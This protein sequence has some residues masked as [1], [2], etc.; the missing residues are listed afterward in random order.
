MPIPARELAEVLIDLESDRAARG[1]VL[2]MLLEDA[3]LGEDSS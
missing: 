3:L 2:G 1:L